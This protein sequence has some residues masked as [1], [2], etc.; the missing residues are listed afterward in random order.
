M[1]AVDIGSRKVGPG[2]PVFVSA[3]IGINHNGDMALAKE[4]IDAAAEAGA[5]SVKFQ[6][7]V[8]DDFVSDRELSFTYKTYNNNG[9]LEEVIEPQFDL[10]KRCELSR[11]DLEEL[12]TH[13]KKR[14]VIIH[15]TPTN[16]QGIEDLLYI[17]APVLKNGS[18]Y[19]PNL[20]LIRA[21]GETGL[22]TVL[23]TGMATV[24][25]IDEAVAAF[26][27]TGNE[28]LIVLHCTSAYP[29]PDEEVNIRRV[30]TIRDTWGCLSGFSDH[31]WGV[32]AAILS[33]A[34]G[35]CW[36]EKHF[37]LDKELRGP[38]HRFSMDSEEL[39]ELVRAVRS[40][41]KQIGSSELGPTQ[42]E[43]DGREGFRLSCVA[44]DDLAVGTVLQ[45]EDIA[46]RRPGTGVRPAL[47]NLL[48]NRKLNKPVKR[49][50]ILN[51]EEDFE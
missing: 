51:P 45:A 32:S 36:V 14:D 37:T 24:T 28:R 11:D 21:M 26:R 23:S 31:S 18:D 5:D 16:R 30:K 19:L 6:N 22:P 40:A 43:W 46:Y 39:R 50:H 33:V 15:S 7:Y 35:A 48:L 2:H 9:Q 17:G 29:T 44:R 27:A 1:R 47:S 20:D 25:E 10:F 4:Q 49:G 13:C 41:E 38:D 34:Y 8:T 42:S 12:A 3:E